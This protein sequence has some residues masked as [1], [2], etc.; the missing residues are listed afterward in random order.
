[1]K[2]AGVAGTSTAA[3]ISSSV[4]SGGSA[5]RRPALRPPA[6][7][8]RDRR[9]AG[10]EPLR[11]DRHR[12]LVSRR[13]LAHGLGHHARGG[14]RGGRLSEGP[15]RL[16]LDLSVGVAGPGGGD[17]GAV[18]AAGCPRRAPR[19]GGAA[20]CTAASARRPRP[21]PRAR[22]CRRSGERC[23]R[24]EGVVVDVERP[25]G[26]G[27]VNGEAAASTSIRAWNG[28]TVGRSSCRSIRAPSRSSPSVFR[29]DAAHAR[30]R[31]A[32]TVKDAVF[33]AIR[34]SPPRPEGRRGAPQTQSF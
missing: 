3:T 19:R 1:M 33:S 26:A 23:R 4:A 7:R 20:G 11:E 5:R 17:G 32:S 12:L 34:P 13:F 22:G 10:D 24:L 29:Q 18:A 30:E 9:L 8:G 16:G 15:E 21:A 25:V 6:A 2:A 27:V 28:L 14:R 31:A